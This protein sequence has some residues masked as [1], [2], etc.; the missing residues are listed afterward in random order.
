[1]SSI[2]VQ[3][4]KLKNETLDEI[5]TLKTSI[6]RCTAN[7]ERL[8]TTKL[9]YNPEVLL[10]RNKEELAALEQ[11]KLFLTTKVE[12]IDSGAYEQKLRDELAENEK[13]IKLK[14]EQTKRKKKESAALSTSS[15]PKPSKP[16]TRA[17]FHYSRDIGRE[18]DYAE[19]Q[20][21]KDCRS[22]PDH[23]REKLANMPH[24]MGYVWRDIWCF[25]EKPS[26]NKEEQTFFEKRNNMFLVHV[27]N[28]RTREYS[29]YEKDNSNRRKLLKRSTY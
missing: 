22:V 21:F 9:K 16:G 8:K 26:N 10:E 6:T 25:G 5:K 17:P 27:Y 4:R 28:R 3:L 18:M 15:A 2:E 23:L 19:K 29:L 14:T 1:M 11:R 13:I 12:E 20:Y 7:V 24:H